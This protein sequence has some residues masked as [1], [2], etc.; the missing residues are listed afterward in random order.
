MTL[1]NIQTGSG[2]MEKMLIKCHRDLIFTKW[3]LKAIYKFAYHFI[4]IRVMLYNNS[5]AW[6]ATYGQSVMMTVRD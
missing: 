6:F 4:M 5:S 3:H 2:N 1:P